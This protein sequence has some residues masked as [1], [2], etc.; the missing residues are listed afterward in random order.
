MVPVEEDEDGEGE[1]TAGDTLWAGTE[2]G[3]SERDLNRIEAHIERALDDDAARCP[4]ESPSESSE[5]P[6]E[7][8][9]EKE[10]KETSKRLGYNRNMVRD[11]WIHGTELLAKDNVQKQRIDCRQQQQ[12]L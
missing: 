2:A 11:I 6:M 9:T 4:D 7:E 12:F 10:D 3:V 1:E 5:P 8:A